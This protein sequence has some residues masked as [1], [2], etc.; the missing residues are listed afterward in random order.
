MILELQHPE[1]GTIRSTG[2][3]IKLSSMGGTEA[4]PAPT[5]GQHN[6]RIYREILGLSEGEYE[7]LK[8]DQVI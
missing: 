7:A 1:A 5:L 3:P 4:S 6:R 2:S 8:A